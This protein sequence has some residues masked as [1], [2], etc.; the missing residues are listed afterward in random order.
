MVGKEVGGTGIVLI[1]LFMYTN[2]NLDREEVL[3]ESGGEKE[4]GIW[5]TGA[6]TLVEWYFCRRVIIIS[7]PTP[8]THPHIYNTYQ[9]RRRG[10]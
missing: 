7:H 6:L 8:Y 10:R 4:E 3:A 2:P 9:R 5:P 1:Y